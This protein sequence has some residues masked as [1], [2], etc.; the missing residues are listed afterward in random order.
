MGL[1]RGPYVR[2]DNAIV[3]THFFGGGTAC[4]APDDSVYRN[5]GS[6]HHRST[7]TDR[8]IDC[9]PFI[10]PV[11][12]ARAGHGGRYRL[13]FLPAVTRT[14]PSAGKSTRAVSTVYRPSS[15][16]TAVSRRPPSTE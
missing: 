6:P 16:T 15:L 3:L 11:F 14:V 8:G 7:M 13:A 1:K 5:P 4:K 10:H 12:S 9:D 2:V